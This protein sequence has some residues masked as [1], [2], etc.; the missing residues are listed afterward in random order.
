MREENLKKGEPRN[1]E[2]GRERLTHQDPLGKDLVLG[3]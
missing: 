1:Q 2:L 3:S